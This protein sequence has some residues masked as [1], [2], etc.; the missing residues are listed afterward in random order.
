MVTD[1]P[2]VIARVANAYVSREIHAPDESWMRCIAHQQDNAMKHC[3]TTS[4]RG[5]DLQD[6]VKD[7]GGMKKLL[8]TRTVA[9]GTICCLTATN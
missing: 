2:A 1:G 6:I 3:M 8:K 5:T 4:M 7:F 9:V